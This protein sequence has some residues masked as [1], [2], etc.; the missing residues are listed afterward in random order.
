DDSAWQVDPAKHS[1][2]AEASSFST[3]LA[4]CVLAK[5]WS[6][7]RGPRARHRLCRSLRA[8]GAVRETQ[9]VHGD[10]MGRRQRCAGFAFSARNEH[11]LRYDG[12]PGNCVEPILLRSRD[13]HNPARPVHGAIA[14]QPRRAAGRSNGKGSGRHECACRALAGMSVLLTGPVELELLAAYR[15]VGHQAAF[16]DREYGYALVVGAR[17]GG[18][19]LASAGACARS[20]CSGFRSCGSSNC[21]GADA[22]SE[23]EIAGG[24][25]VERTLVLEKDDLA[26]CLTTGLQADAELG[27]RRFAND[28][29]LLV[30]VPVAMRATDAEARLANGREHGEAIALRKER[31]A[32]YGILEQLDRFGII[33]GPCG[34]GHKHQK[35]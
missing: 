27:H 31:A 26:I 23:L 29:A 3:G 34:A 12:Q 33:V 11:E 16:R 10:L 2:K 22:R 19:F 30:D 13:C 14:L 28:L 18:V 21:D 17:R 6:R 1:R 20:G 8:A 5:D 15:C 35:Q 25:F 7:P 32:L 9:R 4:T 24:E